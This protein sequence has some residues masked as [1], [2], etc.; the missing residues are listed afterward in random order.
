MKRII[1]F[2]A[3][4]ALAGCSKP[5]DNSAERRYPVTGGAVRS[6]TDYGT[7]ASQS[8]MLVTISHDAHLFIV[9]GRYGKGAM[10]HHPDCTCLKPPR[11]EP[12]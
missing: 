11:V 2:V 3:C 10:M 9:E 7:G 1:V 8:G 12:R 4:L 6:A 5:V